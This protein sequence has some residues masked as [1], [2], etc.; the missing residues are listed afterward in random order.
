MFTGII[1]NV[2][3]LSSLEQ[4]RGTRLVIE[5]KK[6]MDCM[7]ISDSISCSGVCLTVIENNKDSFTVD[8]STETL[9]K[10]T[11][12]SWV[13][14]M[15]INL[16][17]SMTLTSRLGGHLVTGHVDGLAKILEIEREDNSYRL[18]VEAPEYLSAFVATNGSI[19]LDGVSL[20]VNSIN[21]R[22]FC[23][24]LVNYTWNNTTFCD[25]SVGDNLNMEVDLLARYVTRLAETGTVLMSSLVS[26]TIKS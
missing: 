5:T 11:I 21:G 6:K 24:N 22:N 16:E 17:S 7:A 2:G 23:L 1:T 20:T 12:G 15:R 8:V 10:T 3:Y 19:C 9:S 13:K 14:G 25:R 26:P 4:R 18:S